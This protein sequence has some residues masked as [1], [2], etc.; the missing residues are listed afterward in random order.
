M[1]KLLLALFLLPALAFGQSTLTVNKSTGAITGPVSAGTFKTINA[2]VGTGDT[3]TVTETMLAN[4]VKPAVTVVSTSN[5]TLSGEQTIDGQLTSASIVLCTAQSTGSQNGPWVTAAGAWTRPTWYTSGST[6]Q[7]PRFLTTFVRLGTTYSGSTW[8]MTTAGV[9]IDTTATT[10]AQTPITTSSLPVDT[11]GTFASNS[12]TKIATQKAT[13]TYV[14]AATASFDGKASVAYG[15]TTALPSNTY[16]NGSS[17]VG[18]TLTGT[19]NGPLVIDSVTLVIGAVGQRIL[20]A[21]EATQAND[22][23]YTVTQIGTVAVSPYILTRATDSDQ[24]AEIGAGYLTSIIAPN[25]L[26]PGTSNNGKAFISVAADPFTVGTTALTFS[27]VGSTY[28]AGTGLGL[29]GSM[30]SIDTA[31]T[32]DKTTAQSLTNKTFTGS[33]NS[34]ADSGIFVHDTT[35][36]PNETGGWTEYFVTGSDFTTSSAS[37]VDITGL[38]SGTLSATTKYEFEAVLWAV[39]GAD[40]NGLKVG[41]HGGG[42]GTAA[43]VNAIVNATSTAASSGATASMTTIDFATVAFITFS[44][45]NGQINIKGFFTTN[46]VAPITMS[47]QANKVT[48]NSLTI[49]VGSLFRIRKAHT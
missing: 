3:G 44:A 12:D 41:I 21:G 29:S 11:D 35:A 31:T 30:F 49:K 46:S 47:I 9:T 28:S 7:A 33:T 38:V 18:A 19:A 32:V 20:V 42:S 8:R 25:S 48:A 1:K 27:Q 37:L 5:L 45:G 22:G 14:D 23:W 13:K 17:G 26:T 16:A 6:T 15:S 43:T 10:W 40:T 2:I 34:F 39:N 24:A 4:A 36:V